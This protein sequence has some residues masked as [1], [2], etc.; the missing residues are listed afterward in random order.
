MIK[1]FIPALL[2]IFIFSSISYGASS[3][4]IY[5]RKD[6]FDAKMEAQFN[7]LH[8]EIQALGNELKGEIKALESR[9]VGMFNKLEGRLD[10][11]EKRIDATNN[12]LY[13]LLVLLGALL[14]LPSVNKWLEARK[15]AKKYMTLED[16]LKIV[17]EHNAKLRP[18]YAAVK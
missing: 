16:V 9:M 8:G 2:I 7:K 12:F 13:Y 11:M 15:E 10:G 5:V 17:E 1:K 18:E 4:D 14:I 6:V 3:D